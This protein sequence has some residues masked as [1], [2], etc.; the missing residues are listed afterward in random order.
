MIYILTLLYKVNNT[1]FRI[2]SIPTCAFMVLD[3][4][5]TLPPPSER[6]EGLSEEEHNPEPG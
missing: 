1:K 3:V 6:A 5:S 2:L 4:D